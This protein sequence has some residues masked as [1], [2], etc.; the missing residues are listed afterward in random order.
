[1]A[2]FSK[3]G[4][5]LD[6]KDSRKVTNLAVVTSKVVMQGDLQRVCLDPGL[7]T[8]EHHLLLAYGDLDP[9]CCKALAKIRTLY[10]TGKLLSRMDLKG[11][12]EAGGEYW[13]GSSIERLGRSRAADADEIHFQPVIDK[14]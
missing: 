1:M 13:R 8:M 12:A 2:G 6:E 14:T 5:E 11:L 10:H 7:S 4:S 9:L 3:R